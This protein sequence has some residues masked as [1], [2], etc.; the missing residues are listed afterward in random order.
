M[1][2]YQISNGQETRVFGSEFE[3]CEYLG[4]ARCS[5][6]SCCRRGVLCKGYHIERMG[7]SFHRETNTRLHKIWESM[8]E[9]CEYEKHPHY[10]DYGGRGIS[11]CDEWSEYVPFAKW[12]KTNGY[13]DNLTLDR[14]DTYGNYSPDN[15]RWSTMKAQ[16]NNKRNNHR[17]THNGQTHTITEWADILGISKTT[18]KERLLSGWSIEDA[19]ETPVRKRTRGYRP[20][21]SAK[22]TNTEV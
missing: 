1:T 13:A 22:M 3:A 17:L 8:H 15:C 20:S 6:A 7:D 11:V 14:V 21:S 5:V 19:L 16:Q 4:V 10:S 2:H 18:I 12:A 9:R